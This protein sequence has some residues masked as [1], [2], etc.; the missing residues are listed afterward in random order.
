M[1]TIRKI[2]RFVGSKRRAIFN[3]AINFSTFLLIRFV[4]TIATCARYEGITER[5]SNQNEEKYLAT[6][7]FLLC[8]LY[9]VEELVCKGRTSVIN[10]RRYFFI[11]V[12]SD[13][14]R[15]CVICWGFLERKYERLVCQQV[16][17][18]FVKSDANK[19]RKHESDGII[20]VL[21]EV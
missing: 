8:F 19:M 5:G 6:G 3:L 20:R 1:K 4:F 17:I 7:N 12:Y 21:N 10:R 13:R 16:Y 18:F 2:W 11:L 15:N 9:R 14:R